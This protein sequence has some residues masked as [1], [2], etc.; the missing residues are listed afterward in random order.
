MGPSRLQLPVLRNRF[1]QNLLQHNSENLSRNCKKLTAA[2]KNNQQ[3]Q[4][5]LQTALQV[6]KI[7]AATKLYSG[8]RYLKS[9]K[10]LLFR[11]GESTHRFSA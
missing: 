1:F 6:T 10:H 4:K 5:D 11:E 2:K 7:N 9:R 3:S 8:M